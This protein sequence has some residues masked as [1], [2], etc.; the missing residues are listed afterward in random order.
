MHS[1]AAARVEFIYLSVRWLL[2]DVVSEIGS[3]I[4]MLLMPWTTCLR[5]PE[6]TFL[7]PHLFRHP[8]IL[9][10]SY[11]P[12]R[13]W[14]RRF[15]SQIYFLLARSSSWIIHSFYKYCCWE[16]EKKIKSA[17]DT[18]SNKIQALLFKDHVS[19]EWDHP[20][21]LASPGK[22][23]GKF[24]KGGE[25]Q[26]VGKGRATTRKGHWLRERR[27]IGQERGRDSGAGRTNWILHI[28]ARHLVWEEEKK[29]QGTQICG[30]SF[31][32]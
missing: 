25:G 26:A 3:R 32:L 16:T 2:C 11:Y 7:P 22:G 23:T 19:S 13:R 21:G 24:Q 31:C 30:K 17:G 14:R 10:W 15:L 8:L 20:P 6:F 28:N 27:T 9:S 1:T 12:P 18:A 4:N 5:V 29:G